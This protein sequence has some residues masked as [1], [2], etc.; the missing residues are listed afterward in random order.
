M[1]LRKEPGASASA[2]PVLGFVGGVWAAA[3]GA[4]PLR[5]AWREMAEEGWR[6]TFEQFVRAIIWVRCVPEFEAAMGMDT[7]AALA[8]LQP[9]PKPVALG[10]DPA[11]IPGC[12]PLAIP[13]LPGSRVLS[14][15]RVLVGLQLE[16]IGRAGVS[17]AGGGAPWP[18]DTIPG[19]LTPDSVKA[20]DLAGE[21]DRSLV[22]LGG[23]WVPN[24]KVARLL[25]AA[26]PLRVVV[27]TG[28]ARTRAVLKA[29]FSF[30]LR[31][32]AA[33]LPPHMVCNPRLDGF[34]HTVVAWH[35]TT[36]T[37]LAAIRASGGRLMASSGGMVGQAVYATASLQGAMR[38]LVS[39]GDGVLLKL[40]VKWFSAAL[41]RRLPC[42][43]GKCGKIGV[44]HSTSAASYT[45]AVVVVPSASGHA[46][47][48]DTEIAIFQPSR[49]TIVGVEEPDVD[50]DMS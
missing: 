10:T 9:S 42:P 23:V 13:M 31:A 24:T 8:P 46:S 37:K 1:Q 5:T 15:S 34:E 50:V 3:D 28:A 32:A 2:G 38:F 22:P 30:S 47:G 27:G 14:S 21:V 18:D 17:P 6:I 7:L 26:K 25:Y 36:K 4:N 20:A 41:Q 43:C 48:H 11:S 19:I 49:I 44:D 35:A 12:E 39:G 33:A 40:H 16:R 29:S 45:D